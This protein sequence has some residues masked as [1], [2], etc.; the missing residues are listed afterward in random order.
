MTITILLIIALLNITL[1]IIVSNT[2]EGKDISSTTLFLVSFLFSPLV[3]LL[4]SI[5]TPK[6]EVE[7][8]QETEYIEVDKKSSYN[9][10]V[11]IT[12]IIVL[13]IIGFFGYDIIKMLF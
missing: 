2:A 3:G 12:S 7:T 13:S 9:Y 10:P 1:S 6:T 8:T 4:L 5:A 11:I